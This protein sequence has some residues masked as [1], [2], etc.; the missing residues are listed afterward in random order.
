LISD[1]QQ[2]GFCLDE[3]KPDIVVLGF[4]TTLVYEKL[5]KACC[6]IREGALYFE[7]NP[8]F[9]CPMEGGKYIPDCGSIARLIQASTG[10]LPE[11]FGKPS[12][13]ALSYIVEQ[14]GFQSRDI[15]VIGDRLY[16]D[17]A[18]TSGSEASSV[19]VLTGES[20]AED[21]ARGLIKPDLI[22]QSLE[23][24]IPLLQKDS[25]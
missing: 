3:E 14:T 16:T 18:L 19:L 20:T 24:L 4:D 5:E 17:I 15:A 7:V 1:F 21:A 11:F 13:Y 6:F 12:S 2:N 8:D 25:D 9:N 10:R 22:V 23:E